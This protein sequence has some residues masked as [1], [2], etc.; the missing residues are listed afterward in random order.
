MKVGDKVK[1]LSGRTYTWGEIPYT[2]CYGIIA[3]EVCTDYGK[4]LVKVKIRV[5]GSGSLHPYFAINGYYFEVKNLAPL[6]W[7]QGDI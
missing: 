2:E 1:F 5:T 3:S 4:D 6:P 7:E